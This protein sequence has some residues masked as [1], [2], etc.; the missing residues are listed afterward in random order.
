MKF[1]DD[2]LVHLALLGHKSIKTIVVPIRKFV[3]YCKNYQINFH[4]GPR[5]GPARSGPAPGHPACDHV[6][7]SHM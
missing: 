5:A 3:K 4:L 2:I 7:P 6:R 1:F